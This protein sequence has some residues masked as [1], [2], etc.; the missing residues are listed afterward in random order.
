MSKLYV[1]AIDSHSN[2]SKPKSFRLR[3]LS[4]ITFAVTMTVSLIT[5]SHPANAAQPITTV[6]NYDQIFSFSCPQGFYAIE[7]YVGSETIRRFSDGTQQAQEHV[8][9]TFTNSVSG[10]SLSSNTSFL[11][12]FKSDT[13]SEV[14]ASFRLNKPGQGLISLSTGRFVYDTQTGAVVFDSGP[15]DAQPNFCTVLE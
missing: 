9:A 7:H 2:S 8:D 10:L 14:G 15:S 6:N 4:A 1:T 11:F 5:M 3:I 13:V 12:N